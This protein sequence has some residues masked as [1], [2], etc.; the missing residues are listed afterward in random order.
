MI[1]INDDLSSHIISDDG[2][3][4]CFLASHNP[5]TQK[6][7]TSQVEV[8]AFISTV[9]GNSNY[10]Q[11]YKTPEERAQIEA[12]QKSEGNAGRAKSELQLTDWVEN[13]SVRNTALTPHLTN[14]AEFDTYRLALRSIAIVKPSTVDVWP[15]APQAVWSSNI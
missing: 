6:P 5:E 13:A 8:E 2:T 14:A 15:V 3:L 4:E 7:F 12:T 11:P 1:T 10:W 9:Y